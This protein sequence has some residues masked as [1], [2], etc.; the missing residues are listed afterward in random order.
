M[1]AQGMLL[2]CPRPPSAGTPL[3]RT[4]ALCGS[5]G[6]R[7]GPGR[8]PREGRAAGRPLPRRR[9]G[10][11]GPAVTRPRG[12]GASCAGR[13]RG[14]RGGAG[15]GSERGGRVAPR[16]LPARARGGR[17]V[18]GALSPVCL[19][20]HDCFVSLIEPALVP[21]SRSPLPG[22]GARSRLLVCLSPSVCPARLRPSSQRLAV[23]G[24]AD[25]CSGW[26]V[27]WWVL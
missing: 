17:R 15:G 24:E 27:R 10:G 21:R 19:L 26:G 7:S 1:Q 9:A 12:G 14:R 13:R 11:G 20:R 23:E 5:R 16:H 2:W 25:R 22:P 6:R 3:A 4:A 18:L 8:G